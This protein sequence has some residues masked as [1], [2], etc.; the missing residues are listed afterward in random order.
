[1]QSLDVDVQVAQ[2]LGHHLAHLVSLVGGQ[3][4]VACAVMRQHL[5]LAVAV[6]EQE[7]LQL[8]SGVIDEAVLP[9]P[10][11]LPFQDSAGVA[12]EDTAVRHVDIANEAGGRR[13]FLADAPGKYGESRQV[14]HEVHIALGD[15]GETFDR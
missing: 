10:L 7:E 11:Q 4:E 5:E 3:V 9:R 1:M 6:R 8:R 2:S 13:A 15:S 14:G 12:G